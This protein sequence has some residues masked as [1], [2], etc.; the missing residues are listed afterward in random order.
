MAADEEADELLAAPGD[1]AELLARRVSGE[2]LAWVTGT[3]RFCGLDLVIRP[4]VYVPRWQSEQLALT[5]ARLLPPRGTAVDLATGAGAVAAV[6]QDARP[7]ARVLAT[8]LDP[9]AAACA[10]ENG[11]DVRE[12]DLFDPLPAELADRVDVIV[13]VLPYVPR[14]AL[15]LLPRDVLGVEPLLALDG[16]DAGLELVARAVPASTRWLAAG[17]WLLLEVGGDQF[18]PVERLLRAAGFGDLGVLE[19]GDGDLRGIYGRRTGP[20]GDGPYA[21][22]R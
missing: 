15:H 2:P 11:V 13:G 20:A 4:G 18:T 22:S 9:V 19:D 7:E 5:A 17:G 12:G 16:G 8:E 6:L 10:R 21:S 3:H 1:T 14:D